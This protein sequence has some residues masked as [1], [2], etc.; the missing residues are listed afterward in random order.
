MPSAGLTVCGA[1]PYVLNYNLM[2]DTADVGIAKDIC[3]HI[4]ASMA[5]G[6]PG[7]EAMA[8][9]KGTAQQGEY[10]AEVAC[11][12]REAGS[13]AGSTDA[14]SDRV[15][16]WEPRGNGGGFLCARA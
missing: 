2:L 5:G 13:I 12:L 11:N 14:V 9:L 7:V 8:Y 4:R 15:Q 16:G 1:T 6:I 3:K 10:L